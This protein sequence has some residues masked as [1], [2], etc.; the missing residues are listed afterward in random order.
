MTR[1]NVNVLFSR[2][3]KIESQECYLDIRKVKKLI[4]MMEDSDIGEIEIKEGE[5][6][7]RISRSNTTNGHNSNPLSAQFV[8]S[9]R[10]YSAVEETRSDEA[11]QRRAAPRSVRRTSTASNHTKRQVSKENF[12][13]SGYESSKRSSAMNIDDS[14]EQLDQGAEQAIVTAPMVGTFYLAPDPDSDAFVTLGEQV[15]EGDT[16]CI[17]ESMKMMNRVTAE[18]DGILEKVLV[19]NASGVEYDQPLFV[20]TPFAK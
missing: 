17:I 18:I 13:A 15:K 7:V 2:L 3:I 1:D 14:R 5:D 10:A 4:E 8:F 11:R 12:V 9:D 16:L 19:E 6:S 20:L